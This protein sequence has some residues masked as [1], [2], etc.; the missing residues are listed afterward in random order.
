MQMS[1]PLAWS[2]NHT[3]ELPGTRHREDQMIGLFNIISKHYASFLAVS[4]PLIFT[5]RACATL[6]FRIQQ[7]FR[8]MFYQFG[9]E[10]QMTKEARKRTV[11]K[12]QRFWYST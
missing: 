3:K 7:E 8:V 4:N 5:L 6:E 10:E 11:T 9:E 12:L 1:R 2:A